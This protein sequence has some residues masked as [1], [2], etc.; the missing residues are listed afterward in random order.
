MYYA[1]FIYSEILKPNL[2]KKVKRIKE[3]FLSIANAYTVK[4]FNYHM[5]ELEKVDKR[6]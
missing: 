2:K 4:K 3:E 1:S 6:V 5:K